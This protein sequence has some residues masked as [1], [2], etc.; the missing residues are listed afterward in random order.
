ML[1]Y[2]VPGIAPVPMVDCFRVV[3]GEVVE[4]LPYFDPRPL[5]QDEG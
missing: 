5:L 3:N 4:I 2:H 1:D